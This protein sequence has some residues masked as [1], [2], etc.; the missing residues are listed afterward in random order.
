MV[1]SLNLLRPNLH[2]HVHIFNHL[3]DRIEHPSPC[4]AAV[5]WPLQWHL[6]R[7]HPK[8]VVYAKSL[9]SLSLL[10]KSVQHPERKLERI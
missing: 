7:Y 3:T 2:E 4:C 5:L 8:H 6:A 9:P 10:I 1:G